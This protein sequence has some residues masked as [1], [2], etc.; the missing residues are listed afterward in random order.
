[1]I[2]SCILLFIALWSSFYVVYCW[3]IG[4]SPHRVGGTPICFP[5]S[6]ASWALWWYLPPIF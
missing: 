2:L 5:I 1:M 4:S 6:A 3:A